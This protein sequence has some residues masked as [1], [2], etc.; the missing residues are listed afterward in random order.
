[1]D[2]ARDGNTD[3]VPA[4]KL[5]NAPFRG[6]FT[7]A[8][9]VAGYEEGDLI[10]VQDVGMQQLQTDTQTSALVW[11]TVQTFPQGAVEGWADLL[12]DRT[13]NKSAAFEA[14]GADWDYG[15]LTEAAR[16]SFSV[17][18]QAFTLRR[19]YADDADGNLIVTLANFDDDAL[20][21]LK[22]GLLEVGAHSYPLADLTNAEAYDSADNAREFQFPRV[23]A[24]ADYSG[25]LQL[26]VYDPVIGSATRPGLISPAQV[27]ML[28]GDPKRLLPAAQASDSGKIAKVNASGDWALADDEQGTGGGGGGLSQT[29][30]D[31]RIRA[32]TGQTGAAGTF[33]RNRLPLAT[34]TQPGALNAALTKKVEDLPDQGVGQANKFVGFDASGNYTQLDAPSGGGG[35]SS[36]V[37]LSDT[38]GSITANRPVVGNAA[39]NALVFGEF[40]S[41]GGS[42]SVITG[43]S[44]YNQSFPGLT[45]A[46]TDTAVRP[47]APTYFS[48]AFDLDTRGNERGEFHCSLE[49]QIQPVSDVNMGFVNG[50]TNQTGSDRQRSLSNIIFSS[51][52]AQESAFV[53]SATEAL[54][55]VSVFSQP[56][57]SANT[58]VGDYILLLVHNSDN[59]VGIY[60]YW[61]ARAGGTG[62][63]I[64]A[65][66]R[67][68]FT[69][70]DTAALVTDFGTV[71]WTAAKGANVQGVKEWWDG[72]KIGDYVM[73]VVRV[74]SSGNSLERYACIFPWTDS[75]PATSATQG[76]VVH[77]TKS[78]AT[79]GNS[80]TLTLPGT[81]SSEIA[82]ISF[83]QAQASNT[84]AQARVWG[85]RAG[86]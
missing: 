32:Y 34:S 83:P 18:G 29:Q 19:V 27:A 28:G 84:Y 58:Y 48:P 82:E 14:R 54:A 70:T 53:F 25:A 11:V 16:D 72:S 56:V 80:V 68:S 21:K 73:A 10:L 40:P 51:D 22:L 37:D 61:N 49:L 45:L 33:A 59:E 36:F 67:I 76:L 13:L 8:P 79:N 5:N 65:E 71:T 30:V 46:R 86:R 63:T 85:I 62:A 60:H 6:W 50:G 1:M 23:G 9:A 38:P 52:V 69:P 41:S 31:G 43:N 4:A 75:R 15:G 35:S 24:Q 81:A 7:A 26:R 12:F 57:Y 55:G 78:V 20:A 17:G 39:G 2:W 42:S 66:L 77:L 47:A 64:T 74:G 44:L 3:E